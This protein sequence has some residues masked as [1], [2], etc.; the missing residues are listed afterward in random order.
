M[1]RQIVVHIDDVAGSHGANAA[2]LELWDLG[3]VTSGAVMVPCPWFPEIAAIARRRPD[4]DLGVHLTLTAEWERFRWRPLTGVKDNGLCDPDGF[5]WRDVA[6]ARLA[7][8]SAVEAELRAQIDTALA[9][10]IDVTHLDS[11]MGTV[12]MPELMDIYLRLGEDYRL[13]VAITRDLD[14][15]GADRQHVAD[16]MV[17]LAA[18]NAPVFETYIT[19]TFGKAEAMETEYRAML[20]KAPE[21]LSWGAFH[22][23][24]PGDMEFF[25]P[26]IRLRI[27]EHELFRSGR[28]K[29]LLDDAG[30]TAVGMRAYRDRMRG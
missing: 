4:L 22:C 10:G 3:L 19:T 24:T 11:H 2:F 16:A 1:S 5:F 28:F 8:P 6:H 23:T 26:D 9:A 15:M 18:A 30:I 14:R 27:T 25:S 12:W 21:G 7:D 20:A 29:A 13:P 17:R